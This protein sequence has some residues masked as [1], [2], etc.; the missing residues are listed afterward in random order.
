MGMILGLN[1]STFYTSLFQ[2]N[3]ILYWRTSIKRI[4]IDKATLSLVQL[5]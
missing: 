2:L 4:W 3:F 1:L 5:R